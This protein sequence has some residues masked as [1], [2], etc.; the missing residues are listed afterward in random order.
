MDFKPF[1]QAVNQAFTQMSQH[2]LFVLDV[3]VDEL[4]GHYL[5]SFPAGTNPIYI[6]NTEH[7]CSCCRNFVKH[8]G[9]VVCVANGRIQ[10]VW[11]DAAV[12]ADIGFY[13]VVANQM[14]EF[15]KDKPIKTV[16]RTSEPQYG[17]ELTKQH[18]EAGTR[19]WNHFWGKIAPRHFTKSPGEARGAIEAKVQVFA[20]GLNELKAEAL[21]SIVELIESNGLYRGEEHLAAVKGFYSL[22]R[23]Y[24]QAKTDFERTLIVLNNFDKPFTQFR[25]T[26]IGTL[27]VDLSEG[28]DLEDAVKAFEAKVAPANYKR[29]KALI[30]PRMVQD[31]ARAQAGSAQ[32]RDRDQAG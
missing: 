7:D 4:W 31:A 9:A 15:L 28:V 13:A 21:E 10:T 16:F 22:H 2:E 11:D 30:T 26:V 1:A 18:L 17:A 8:L 32:A 27:A 20:R 24:Q 19:N 25:N 23:A 5:A 6:T 29:P 14:R 3:D 12:L